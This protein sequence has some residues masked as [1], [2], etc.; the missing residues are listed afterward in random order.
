MMPTREA[1]RSTREL[2]GFPDLLRAEQAAELLG[3]SAATLNRSGAL[4]DHAKM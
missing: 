3:N 1:R 4:R 2:D